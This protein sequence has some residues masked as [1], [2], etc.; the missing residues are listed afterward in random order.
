MS[1]D[2]ILE[3]AKGTVQAQGINISLVDSLLGIVF[4]LAGFSLFL[5]NTSLTV[6]GY[7]VSDYAFL[8]SVAALAIGWYEN[9]T[10]RSLSEMGTLDTIAAAG[11]GAI[12][13]GYE[14]L[15]QFADMI[16]AE[17]LAQGA[18]LVVTMTGWFVVA[19][20]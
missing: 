10:S 20:K 11:T 7:A 8:A 19:I 4:A 2:G 18:A 14:F 9:D 15:P 12:L 1:A 17:P 13:I 6:Y 5:P 3:Q 16:S